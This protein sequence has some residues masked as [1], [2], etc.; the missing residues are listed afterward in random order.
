MDTPKPTSSRVSVAGPWPLAWLNGQLTLLSGPEAALAS[1]SRKPVEVEAHVILGTSGRSGPSSSRSVD[2]QRSLESRLR[3]RLEGL[4]S[5][6]YALKWKHW[7]MESGEPICAQ[8]GSALRTSGNGSGSWPTPGVFDATNSNTPEQWLAR[9]KRNPNMSSSSFPTALSVGAQMVEAGWGTP[10]ENQPGGTA[11]QALERKRKAVSEGKQLGVSVTHLVH[12][13]EMAGWVSPTV[14]D[15][16]RGTKPPRPQDT[17]VPLS[18]QVGQISTGS[19]AQ[20]ASS[21]QLNPAFSLWLMGFGAEFLWC[22][23][24]D[25]PAPRFR[26]RGGSTEPEL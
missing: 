16:S 18:Q 17:G 1:R 15:H 3:A 11:E 22:A 20:T 25:R 23:P 26:K 8:R 9:Q 12:Q 2:L 14:Q 7:D 5:P 4:G 10:T 6:L 21:G 13:A 19:P 24:K